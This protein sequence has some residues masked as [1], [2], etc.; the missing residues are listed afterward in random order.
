MQRHQGNSI[1]RYKSC[2]GQH[3]YKTSLKFKTNKMLR[4]KAKVATSK[5]NVR[6]VCCIAQMAHKEGG[7]ITVVL[8]TANILFYS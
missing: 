6:I 3:A 4:K 1:N 2:Y 8:M 5:P 7:T